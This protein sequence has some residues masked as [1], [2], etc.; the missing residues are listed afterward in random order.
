MPTFAQPVW[1]VAGLLACCGAVFFIALSAARRTKRL[2]Q[3]AAP[4][5]LPLLTANV[6]PARR[7]LKNACFL[8]G[9]ACVFLALARPQLGSRVV[10]LR[11]RG[12]DILIAFDVSKSM[13]A[14]DIRPNRLERAK[15]ALRDF[16]VRLD[17]DRIGLLPFAGASFLF[18]PLTTD[19]EAFAD[20]LAALNSETIPK[21]GTGIG[22]VIR[23]AVNVLAGNSNY[24]I[25]VLITDG[26]DLGQDALNAADIARQEKMIIHTVG[27]GTPQGSLIPLPAGGGNFIKDENGFVVSKLDEQ[28]L[29]AIAETTGGI[30]APLGAMGEGLDAVYERK[31]AMIPKEEQ[32]VRK[33]NVPIERFQWPLSAAVLLF[34]AE[35]LLIGRRRPLRLPFIATVGRRRKKKTAAAALLCCGLSFCAAARADEGGELF[36]AGQYKEAAAYYQSRMAQGGSP[37]LHFNL[38]TALHKLGQHDAAAEE[39]RRALQTDDLSLQEKSYY[40]RGV[41]QYAAGLEAERQERLPQAVEQ[42][43]QAEESLKAALSLNQKRNDAEQLLRQAEARRQQI[44]QRLKEPPPQADSKA[45]SDKQEQK[46]EGGQDKQSAQDS[47][48]K[49]N[50]KEKKESRQQDDPKQNSGESGLK[51]SEQQDRQPSQE[52][53]SRSEA[54][55]AQEQDGKQPQDKQDQTS[56]AG[57]EKNPPEGQGGEETKMM[58]K[59]TEEEARSL[60]DSL[61]GEQGELSFIPQ[62]AADSDAVGRDW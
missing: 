26:E 47:K 9:L 38:G 52:K 21:G 13:L 49:D 14:Q 16:A 19:Y 57:E 10:E 46:K 42:L 43:R 61:K 40:N 17:G 4:H 55:A 24:K 44:E 34:S 48:D 51:E 12:I 23:E 29:V 56:A 11:S 30:Y 15:L 7:R 28:T 33:K 18:C 6:S 22:A 45:S 58:G 32:G 62:E 31:L 54:P 35:F 36:R 39:F 53:N 50:P 5:L 41:S 59:M 25:L 8:L 3:F 2:A 1:L 20:S 37:A 27:V 60:L